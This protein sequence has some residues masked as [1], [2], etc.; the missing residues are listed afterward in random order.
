[1]PELFVGHIS[2]YT[3]HLFLYSKTVSMMYPL[4]S[5][6]F[7]WFLN[8]QGDDWS[9]LTFNDAI[10][11]LKIQRPLFSN[12]TIF[13]KISNA[14]NHEANVFLW[15]CGILLQMIYWN[16]EIFRTLFLYLAFVSNGS[17]TWFHWIIWYQRTTVRLFDCHFSH[18]F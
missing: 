12:F 10:L 13:R 6:S 18:G 4:P 1:M 8:F 14:K 2:R 3:Y 15:T 16:V 7:H 5:E 9:E 17:V 11:I